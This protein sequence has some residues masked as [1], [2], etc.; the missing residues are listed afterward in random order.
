MPIG[1]NSWTPA[2]VAPPTGACSVTAGCQFGGMLAVVDAAGRWVGIW[3]NVWPTW[4]G[5]GIAAR[6]T[7]C[8]AS[9]C[10]GGTVR[11]TRTWVLRD[12]GLAGVLVSA[13]ATI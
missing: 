11:C 7:G 5:V 13:L 1:G 3:P 6:A 2:G 9:G 12:D 4:S 10:A 8:T